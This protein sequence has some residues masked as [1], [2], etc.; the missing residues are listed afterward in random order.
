MQ[1]QA[2]SGLKVYDAS[3]GVAGPHATMLLAQH[4][5]DVIK[6]EPPEGDWCRN[7]GATFGDHCAHSVAFNRGKRA[8]AF[9]LK[10]PQGQEI[11]HKLAAKADVFVESFRPGVAARIGLDYQSIRRRNPK[12]V[13][14]SLSGFGQ[15]GPYAQRPTVDSLIQAHSGMAVMNRTQDGVP[16]RMPA[17]LIDIVSG[18]Y[19]FQALAAAIIRQFRFGQGDYIDVSLMQSA[20]ALQAPKIME[21]HLEKGTPGELYAPL[22]VFATTDGYIMISVRHD[23][24]FA[25]LCTLIDRADLAADPRYANKALRVQNIEAM[26]AEIRKEFVKRPSAYW[27]AGLQQAGVMS[28]RVNTYG[29]WLADPQVAHVDC[30]QWQD[31]SGVGRVPLIDIPGVPPLEAD[32][33]AAHAPHLGEHSRTI[34]GE[35]SYAPEAIDQLIRSGIVTAHG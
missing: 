4:G 20:A 35:I 26:T 17:V 29:E 19:L 2:F 10:T 28:E 12:V 9:D 33:D 21:F 32:G 31:H 3:Q 11:A 16:H 7:L 6:V 8:I 34:L 24:H 25:D 18:L 13:Y 27:L 22:G 14:A 23:H 15:S 30:V 1:Q 5:A